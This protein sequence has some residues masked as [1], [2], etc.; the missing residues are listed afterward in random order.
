MGCRYLDTG[1][2]LSVQLAKPYT[3]CRVK[4]GAGN[5]IKSI[6]CK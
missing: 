6:D 2:M 4:Y 1:I 3:E 5:I